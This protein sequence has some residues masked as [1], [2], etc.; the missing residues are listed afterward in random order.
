MSQPSQ[1]R[2][3]RSRAERM[4][5]GVS[6]GIGDYF[7]VDPVLV[8]LGWVI[9]AVASGGLFALAYLL[10]WIIVPLEG[11]EAG[12]PR[13]QVREGVNE[14]AEEARA[15]ARQVRD[16]VGTPEGASDEERIERHQR[17][18]VWAGVL[19]IT[20]GVIFLF[21]NLQLVSWFN[22]HVFWPLFLVAAGAVLLWQ[23]LRA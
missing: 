1:R 19:L 11:R 12:S 10:L 6:G 20:L 14:L 16:A 2:L 15:F 23:R 9:L 5:S 17:R 18:H 4:I 21:Q 13:E 22:W 7:D 3:Y 8:R